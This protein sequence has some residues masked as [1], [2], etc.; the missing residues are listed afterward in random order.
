M[1]LALCPNLHVMVSCTVNVSVCFVISKDSFLKALIQSRPSHLHA[2][3]LK[4]T[5]AMEA[6]PKWKCQE[7][8]LRGERTLQ[9]WGVPSLPGVLSSSVPLL[10]SQY[11]SVNSF[12][13]KSGR[14][15]ISRARKT[16]HV[17]LKG[18]AHYRI[19]WLS[20]KT[21]IYIF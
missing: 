13:P 7:L 2:I 5:D 9:G 11:H 8:V 15:Q 12:D 16:P 4:M 19:E 20:N 18:A 21:E 1:N 6:A 3:R 17:V 10:S 14:K